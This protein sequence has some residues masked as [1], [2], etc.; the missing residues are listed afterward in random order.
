[1]LQVGR[2]PGTLG[3][4]SLLLLLLVGSVA[5]AAGDVTL[6][7]GARVFDGERAV[8]STDVLVRGGKI[9]QVGKSIPAPAGAATVDGSGC[10]LLP[11]LIDCHTHVIADTMLE[12]A[13]MFG[14]TTELDMF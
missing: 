11:G 2:V 9:E 8:D 1:M 14:V 7:R 12:Q 10:T 3:A 13:L 6:I 5:L 4:V